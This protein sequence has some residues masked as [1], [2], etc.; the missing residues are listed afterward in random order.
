MFPTDTNMADEY[1]CR[2]S[3]EWDAF[4]WWRAES[5]ESPPPEPPALPAPPSPP[6]PHAPGGG[7]RGDGAPIGLIVGLA[8]G[9]VVL[10]LGAVLACRL[11]KPGVQDDHEAPKFSTSTQARKPTASDICSNSTNA[12]NDVEMANKRGA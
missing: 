1:K 5:C 3:T 11:K 12:T 4:S 7:G 8:V 6:A 9:A 10:V 2:I